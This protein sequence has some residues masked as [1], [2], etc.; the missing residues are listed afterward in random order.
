L[1]CFLWFSLTCALFL[2]ALTPSCRAYDSNQW[3]DRWFK[4]QADTRAWSA[5]LVQTRSLK[6]LA[7]PLVSTGKVWVAMPDRFRWELGQPAQTIALRE[8]NSLFVI[9]P[10]LKRV[11]KYP[12]DSSQPGPWKDALSLLEASFPR[13]RAQMD[14]QFKLLSV[15]P[16]N[17]CVQVVLQPRSGFAR[18]FMNE[19][20][21][22]FSTNNF[23]LVATELK[24]SDGSNM[25]S[26]F[27]NSVF[28][29]SLDPALFD[30]SKYTA[31]QVVEPLGQ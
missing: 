6:V 23:S 8:T 30:L 28:N 2:C 19:I 12:L 22:T 25:R 27:T 26:D 20:Q 29:A 4:A 13:S 10:K 11:E 24:F 5:D 15:A 18:K 9:Y 21:V 31:F 16:T 1:P 7:Q 17:S 14:S 3:L